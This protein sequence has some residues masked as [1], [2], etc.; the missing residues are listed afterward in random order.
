MQRHV[1]GFRDKVIMGKHYAVKEVKDDE[2]EI[3]SNHLESNLQETKFHFEIP[4]DD[5][6][7]V[8]HKEMFLENDSNYRDISLNLQ[9][10][11]YGY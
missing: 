7:H 6:N 2:D 10:I 11:D 5:P 8:I 1:D 9:F 4:E 3:M